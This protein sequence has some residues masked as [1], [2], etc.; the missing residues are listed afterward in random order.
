[1]LEQGRVLLLFRRWKLAGAA[2][3]GRIERDIAGARTIPALLHSDPAEAAAIALAVGSTLLLV[4]ELG[5]ITGNWSRRCRRKLSQ[6]RRIAAGFVALRR[7]VPV[8]RGFNRDPGQ[9][10][11]H[12]SS[13]DGGTGNLG[14]FD[15]GAFDVAGRARSRQH[16]MQALMRRPGH[17]RVTP[18]G[19]RR[20]HRGAESPSR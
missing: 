4:E 5:P 13:H 11:D 9:P 14:G 18:R 20:P 8:R 12:G 7:F 3:Q 1:L 2:E 15:L 16:S 19:R 17:P 10:G 6:L